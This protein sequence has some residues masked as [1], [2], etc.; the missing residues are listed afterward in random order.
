MRT[1]RNW[2][3][4]TGSMI[5]SKH[6]VPEKIHEMKQIVLIVTD[7]LAK[8]GRKSYGGVEINYNKH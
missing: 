4:R 3:A 5:L 2:P 6:D 7:V 1:M 8:K